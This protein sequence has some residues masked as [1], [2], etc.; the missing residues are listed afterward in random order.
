M[1][2]SGKGANL[3]RSL[4]D[5]EDDLERARA[6]LRERGWD[7]VPIADINDIIIRDDDGE[8]TSIDTTQ[9]VTLLA[10]LDDA[11][12]EIESA[13]REFDREIREAFKTFRQQVLI[14][15]AAS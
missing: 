15:E 13:F 3:R 14:A 2:D 11:T 8:P 10:H 1:T 12:D 4:R 5:L 6:N 7:A 9:I